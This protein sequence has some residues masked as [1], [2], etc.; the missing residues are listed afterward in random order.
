VI[1]T[2]AWKLAI[3]G[4]A[5]PFT[6]MSVQANP[7]WSLVGPIGVIGFIILLAVLL[8]VTPGEL[9]LIPFD[10]PEAETELAGGVLVEY[11]GRNLALF[12]ITQGVK[13]VAIASL[14]VALF[15]PYSLAAIVGLSGFFALVINV[16][17]YIV[18]ITLIAFISVSLVRVSMTRFRINQVVSAYW[19]YISVAGLIGLLL[20]MADQ[21][22]GVV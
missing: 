9:S 2:V 14:V 21:F 20:V 19:I 18:L 17:F 16:V 6:L 8:I 1:I 3:S 15:F 7:V 12:S 22:L 10:T 5:M 13:I 4:I 11:S